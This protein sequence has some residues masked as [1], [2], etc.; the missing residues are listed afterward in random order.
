MPKK[1]H[2]QCDLYI[3]NKER[4]KQRQHQAPADVDIVLKIISTLA[5]VVIMTVAL[6]RDHYLHRDDITATVK[7]SNLIAQNIKFMQQVYSF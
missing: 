7:K 6:P 5:L 1:W 2:G 4:N 3:V